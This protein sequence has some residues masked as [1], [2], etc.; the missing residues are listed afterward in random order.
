M[1]FMSRQPPEQ[2]TLAGISILNPHPMGLS[3]TKCKPTAFRL[4]GDMKAGI[5]HGNMCLSEPLEASEGPLQNQ[6]R[7]GDGAQR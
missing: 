3:K 4:D 2:A 7:M 6:A 1:P 5:S